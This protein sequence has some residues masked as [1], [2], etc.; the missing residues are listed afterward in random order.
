MHTV[1]TMFWLLVAFMSMFLVTMAL[2]FIF[3]ANPGSEP[4]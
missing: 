2:I 4:P 3:L 1:V